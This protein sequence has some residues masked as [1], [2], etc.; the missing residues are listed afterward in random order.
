MFPKKLLIDCVDGSK[1][2]HILHE[3]LL[4]YSIIRS[5]VSRTGTNLSKSEQCPYRCLND[6]PN[7]A[8]ASLNNTLQ[9]LECSACL[10]F[11]TPLD[12]IASL[13]IEAEASGNEHK[14]WAHDGLTIWP[15]R[16][17]CICSMI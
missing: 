5:N 10:G 2:V 17:R 3:D 9:I 1:I 15:K 14:G 8:P 16:L 12:E 11:H 6:L 7:M 13:R 4:G